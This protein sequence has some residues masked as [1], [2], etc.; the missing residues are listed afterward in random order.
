M[1][2]PT[3][4]RKM[5]SHRLDPDLHCALIEYARQNRRSL[6]SA[7]AVLLEKALRDES[8]GRVRP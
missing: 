8:E 5:V 7:C 4:T 2:A 6:S 1:S 3:R